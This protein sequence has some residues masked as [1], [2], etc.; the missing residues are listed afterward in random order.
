MRPLPPSLR[1]LA[2]A[3]VTESDVRWMIEEGETLVELKSK[4]PSE[5]LGPTISSFANTIGGWVIL[6]VDDR[7]RDVVGWEPQGRADDLDYL[8]DLLRHQVD[9][10]PPFAA[11]P[12]ELNG[13]RISVIRV[14]ESTDTPHIV[15]GTGSV[16]IRDPG[17]KR[18]IQDH[19]TVVALARRGEEAARLARQRLVKTPA[20]ASLLRTPDSPFWAE[21]HPPAEPIDDQ[22]TAARQEQVDRETPPFPDVRIV[23]R[24]AP[25][26]VTPTVRDWPLTAAASEWVLEQADRLVRSELLGGMSF[27][28]QGPFHE[29]FGRAIAARVTQ[30]TG[31][32]ARDEAVVVVDSAGVVGAQIYRGALRGDRPTILLDAMLE[33][34]LVPLS[35]LV[36]ETLEAA[37]A[38]G[39][40]AAELWL[41][42]PPGGMLHG[43]RREPDRV[44]RSVR[45]LTIPADEAAVL[46]LAE[47]W[48]RELQRSV[49]IPKY[50][51]GS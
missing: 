34:E 30:V 25:Y 41:L 21:D 1:T 36:V 9:P 51:D 11:K 27:G 42:F 32:D 12:L 40:A 38:V 22:I 47:G 7:T 48:H 13:Q 26:T 5:G 23:A 16:Y 31:P 46:D 15:R 17:A 33:D 24:A 20:V 44:L 43:A 29:V 39:R 37:E 14:Y 28:R 10:L 8:R 50:E 49:G 2:L 45:E 35:R 3:D 19:A 18:P 6:G 4:I